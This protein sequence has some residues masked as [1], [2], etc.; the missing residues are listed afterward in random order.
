MKLKIVCCIFMVSLCAACY[1]S[2]QAQQESEAPLI[3]QPSLGE[4]IVTVAACCGI[5]AWWF[6]ATY[7]Q[8]HAYQEYIDYRSRIHPRWTDV[9]SDE[10]LTIASSVEN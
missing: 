5:I 7:Y 6:F 8:H 10:F 3:E 9:F 2:S 4:D 1:N